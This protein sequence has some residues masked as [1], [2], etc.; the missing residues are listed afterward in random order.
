LALEELEI[1]YNEGD[2]KYS[3]DVMFN[4]GDRNGFEVAMSSAYGTKVTKVV[5][6]YLLIKDS[7]SQ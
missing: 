7:Y 3:Y 4:G 2:P 6:R 5:L 1:E